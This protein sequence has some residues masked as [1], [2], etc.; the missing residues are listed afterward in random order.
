MKLYIKPGACSLAV[1]IVANEAGLSI[2]TENVDLGKKLTASGGDYLAINPKGQVPALQLDDGSVLSEGP[3]IAQYMADQ[4]SG[5]ALMPAFGSVA[6]YRVL[7][8][9]NFITSELHKGFSPLF[10]PRFPADG[11]AVAAEILKQRLSWVDAQLAGKA[12]LTGDDFTVADA[13]LF[14][15]AGWAKYVKLDLSDLP[16]LLAFLARVAA[17]PAVIKSLQEEGLA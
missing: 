10:N 7:E 9:Q 11:K 1:H 5:T 16:N 3:V 15:V 12:Y 17:R 8:W 13:Y 2:P 4:V 14:T 6:R